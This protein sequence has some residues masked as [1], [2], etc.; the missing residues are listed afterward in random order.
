LIKQALKNAVEI[1]KID[2]DNVNEVS[3]IIQAIADFQTYLNQ[4]PTR[5]WA[6]L[7]TENDTYFNLLKEVIG[8]LEFKITYLSNGIRLT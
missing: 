2:K 1:N 5:D 8:G 6:N 3:T 4:L 7:N